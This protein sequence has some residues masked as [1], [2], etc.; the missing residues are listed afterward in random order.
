MN[1]NYLT[2]KINYDPRAIRQDTL[3]A[4]RGDIIVGLIEFI[5]NSD[6]AYRKVKKIGKI[7]IIYKN[8]EK[9]FKYSISVRDNAR[10][11]SASELREK[12]LTI[13]KENTD[14][15]VANSS[16]E[17]TRGL[18][19]RGAKDVAVFGKARFETIFN[20][21]FSALEIDG[22]TWDYTILALD[23]I[24]SKSH[25]A[26]LG[27]TEGESGFSAE[28]MVSETRSTT[29]PNSKKIVESLS[30]HVALREINE[31]HMVIFNDLRANQTSILKPTKPKGALLID[32]EVTVRGY[33]KK[34]W[35]Q[36]W[37]LNER[38]L[39][40]CDEYSLHGII[41]KDKKTNF[42]NTFLDLRSRPEIGWFHGEL[43]CE[44]IDDLNRQFDSNE[45]NRDTVDIKVVEKNPMRLA[46]K[47][48]DGLD[49]KHPYYR[50]LAII[51]NEE[52]KPLMDEISKSEESDK[53]VSEDLQKKLDEASKLLAQLLQETLDEEELDGDFDSGPGPEDSAILLIPPHKV[54]EMG[55]TG[56]VTAWIPEEN[57]DKSKV[58]L[59]F[60][61]TSNFQLVSP[62]EDVL[63]EKHPTRKI[64]KATVQVKALNYGTTELFLNYSG[65]NV[66]SKIE[67]L[68]SDQDPS[69]MI[70]EI[71]F[72]KDTY[73]LSPLRKRTIKILAPAEMHKEVFKVQV[74]KKGI[75]VPEIVEVR[76]AKSRGYCVGR[77]DTLPGKDEGN[78]ILEVKHNDTVVKTNLVVK[79]IK[80]NKGP[81][82]SIDPKNLDSVTRS[83]LL[84]LPGILN[85]QIYLK[86]KGIRKLLGPYVNDK[87]AN[88]DSHVVKA[89]FSEIVASE[90]ANYVIETEF[91]KR[92]HL[93]RDPSSLIRKQK[94]LMTKFNVA[95]QISLLA[96]F[97]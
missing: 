19:G 79:D 90:L 60:G 93:Y 47:S 82:I 28:I 68:V 92:S 50:S 55:R 27:L 16:E 29:I 80:P 91:A 41:I 49:R 63:F 75:V 31:K 43:L 59:S 13:G 11:L 67:C 53:S 48:R 12:F 8:S 70:N 44:E 83:S 18:F 23:E 25:Y 17:G 64:M 10:G 4:M 37:K 94:E 45:T 51:L 14:N 87:Y 88:I 7:E 42:Q 76:L 95:M 61:D 73:Y 38:Q 26:R 71:V 2:G 81:T 57:F 35:L 3:D 52:L 56:H 40:E 96:E 66:Q 21:R 74:N 20:N 69:L 84:P 86:H 30:N 1:E 15:A 89:V 24:A 36:V 77:I 33:T 72:E 65:E 39:G 22:F 6:D 46:K 97:I 58:S 85:I 5:T 32:K 9:P 54:I 34:A 62:L 78:F